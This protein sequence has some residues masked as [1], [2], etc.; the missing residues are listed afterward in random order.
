MEQTSKTENEKKKDYLRSYRKHVR[1]VQRISVELIDGTLNP[2]QFVLE[3][4]MW[5]QLLWFH[6][7]FERG[8][9]SWD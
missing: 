9:A 7:V 3:S 8:L 4:L 2:G 1:R 6:S 5:I